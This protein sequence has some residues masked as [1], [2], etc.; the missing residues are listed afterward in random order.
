M[1]PPRLIIAVCLLTSSIRADNWP[2]FRGPTG[3]GLT[4]E[5]GLPLEWSAKDHHNIRWSVP[6]P[7]EGHA[8]PIVWNDRVFTCTVTWSESAADR[9]SIPTHH[10]TCYSTADGKQLWDTIVPPGQWL[11][12]D[13]RSGPGGGYAAPTPCTDGQHVFVTFGSAVMASLDF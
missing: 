2:Q 4:T 5:K 13:F 1:F 10:V 9:K 6:L 8:S 7:G 12:N 11:R 3:M